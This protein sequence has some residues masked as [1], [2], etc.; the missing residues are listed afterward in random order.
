M[1]KKALPTEAGERGAGSKG[2]KVSFRK[3]GLTE[4]ESKLSILYTK[5]QMNKGT[6]KEKAKEEKYIH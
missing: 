3:T 2:D 1:E 5:E 6:H 4:S